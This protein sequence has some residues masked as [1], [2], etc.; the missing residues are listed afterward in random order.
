MRERL[1]ALLDGDVDDG[2][3]RV[4][5]D[6]LDADAALR[7]DWDSWCLIGDAIRGETR[8]MPDF[9]SRV[10]TR[11]DDEPT[12]LAP[13]RRASRPWR[14]GWRHLAS[15]AASVMGVLA[16]AGVVAS[17]LPG[18]QEKTLATPRIATAVPA[19]PAPVAARD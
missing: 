8:Y 18:E 7:E 2:M 9:V 12:V 19:A 13:Q 16:V 17:R 10:M 15:V 4:L 11:L 5:F 1:S 14:P 3:A 6:R